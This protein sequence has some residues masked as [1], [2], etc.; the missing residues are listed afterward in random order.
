MA[1]LLPEKFVERMSLDL[2]DAEGRALCEALLSDAPVSVRLNPRKR[3]A[4]PEGEPIGWSRCGIRLAERPVFTLDTAFHAGRYYVQE[5]GSQFVGHILETTGTGDGRIL[6]MC[7]AP[8]GKTTLYS[9]LV[10]EK[11]LVVANDPVRNRASVLA[12]NVRKWGI[13]NVVV[14]CDEPQHIAVFENRF[15]VVAV[16][17]PCSGEGMFRKDERAREEWSENNVRMCAARQ[18]Q[19]L[20]SAWH[21]L[22]PSGVLIYS[23]CTFNRTENEGVLREFSARVGGELAEAECI[24]CDDAWGVVAGREGVFQ[25][26]R[27]YPHRACAEGFFVAVARKAASDGRAVVPKPRR[28]IMNDVAGAVRKELSRWVLHPENMR[29]ADVGGTCYGYYADT[30]DEVRSFAETVNV[31]YSGVA[32]GVVYN[33]KLKPDAA[34]AMFVDLNENAVP[35]A[36]LE[37]EEALRYLR[38]QDIAASAFAEG[39]NLVKSGGCALGFVKRIGNRCNNMYP[40]SLRILKTDL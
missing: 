38:K 37:R 3:G 29:F 4:H 18:L 14:A 10:G 5:A 24:A 11:G 35:V 21:A 1:S 15:D 32:M 34:L 30:Y 27:F 20:D 6:D 39:V 22:R 28:R 25:T 26:F 16:D 23:T 8:G 7:A 9:A 40:N 2:G 12:D 31:I 19:I 13:G 33:G 17:A 36:E